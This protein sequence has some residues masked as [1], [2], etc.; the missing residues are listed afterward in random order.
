MRDKVAYFL[1]INLLIFFLQAS[2]VL[3][4]TEETHEAINYYV[5]RN[6]IA[7]YR[8]GRF[9]LND[10][11]KN[12]LG[13]EDGFEHILEGQEEV[14][15][16]AFERIMRET[17][18]PVNDWLG[19]GGRGEDHPGHWLAWLSHVP[20]RAV[21]HFHNPLEPWEE[22]GLNDFDHLGRQWTGQSSVL[23]SQ[24]RDQDIGGKWSWQDGQY[25]TERYRIWIPFLHLRRALSVDRW[26]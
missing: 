26:G 11:L 23:W 19:Y 5:A 10:Y 13:F 15:I 24:N 20:G 16:D 4:F 14:N 22:A 2:P 25:Y 9:S 7:D 1:L 3:S 17:R 6:T 12:L 8:G 18:K 21:N